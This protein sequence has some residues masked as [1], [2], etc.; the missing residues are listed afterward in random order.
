MTQVITINADEMNAYFPPL[1]ELDYEEPNSV[2][3]EMELDFVVASEF[4]QTVDLPVETA[5]VEAAF[6]EVAGAKKQTIVQEAQRT[7][8]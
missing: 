8:A 1:F 5:V 4:V 3:E 2:V 6:V 7:A